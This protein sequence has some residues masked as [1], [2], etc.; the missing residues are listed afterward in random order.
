MKTII[1]FVNFEFWAEVFKQFKKSPIEGNKKSL[2]V[3]QNGQTCSKATN[4]QRNNYA[5]YQQD[6]KGEEIHA[7]SE[8]KLRNIRS[9][10][11]TT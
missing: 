2:R 1:R 9:K 11:K 5:N 6:I 4:N 7:P 3:P 8:N 10:Y